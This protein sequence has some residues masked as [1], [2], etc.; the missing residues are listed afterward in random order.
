MAGVQI[1]AK[2]LDRIR[3]MIKKAE[4][5]ATARTISAEDIVRFANGYTKTLGISKK[6]LAGTV[7]VADLNAQHFPNAYKYTPEST[8]FGLKATSSGWSLMWVERKVCKAPTLAY[9][10]T[11]TEAAKE[12]I[13]ARFSALAVNEV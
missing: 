7:V 4:G 10:A 1:N 2:N 6:A 5:R 8:Q 13:L 3:E 11:F 12:A 9:V